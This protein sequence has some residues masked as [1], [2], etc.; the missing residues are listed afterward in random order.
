MPSARRSLPGCSASIE[1]AAHNR[2]C[3]YVI[4]NL[5]VTDPETCWLREKGFPRKTVVRGWHDDADYKLLSDHRRQ[6]R[7]LEF[8][9]MVRGLLTRI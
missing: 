2:Y 6:G 4:A 8:P 3:R 9:T 7:R 1:G 5:P